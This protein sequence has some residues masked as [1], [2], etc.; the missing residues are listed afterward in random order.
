MIL[1]VLGL[2]LESALRM[3]KAADVEVTDIKEI[4]A[5]RGNTPRGTLRVV[6]VE[7]GGKI[8]TCARFPDTIEE[9]NDD[10]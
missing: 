8:I 5:P 9:K 6:R 10:E 7:N 2:P 4:S 3:L 1:S